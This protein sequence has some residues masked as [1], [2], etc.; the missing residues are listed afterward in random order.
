MGGNVHRILPQNEPEF[1]KRQENTHNVD[2]QI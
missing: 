1:T 2:K